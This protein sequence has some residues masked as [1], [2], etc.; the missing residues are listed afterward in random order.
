MRWLLV[1]IIALGTTVGDVLQSKGMR[2]HGEIRDFSPG[3]IRRVLATVLRDPR[4]LG[5]VTG[6]AVSFFAFL[7]LLSIAQI[8]FAVPATATSYVLETI[9][10]RYFLKE[11]VTW[12]RWA[13]A[14]L[15][16]CGV[17]LLSV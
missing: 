10:A 1:L 13:G 4:I 2:H 11:R 6:Y 3:A 16:A 14:V 8:S 12:H 15:V 7:R 5:A 17:A 9:L